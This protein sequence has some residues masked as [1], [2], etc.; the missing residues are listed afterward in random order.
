MKRSPTVIAFGCP[1]RSEERHQRY[2]AGT[3]ARLAEPDSLIIEKRGYDSIQQPLN[4]ILEESA[5]A[6]TLEAVVLLHEDTEIAGTTLLEMVRWHLRDPGIGVIG[7]VGAR[8]VETSCWWKYTMRGACRIPNVTPGLFFHS[9]GP[10][11]V[12]AVD[13]FLMIVSA[14][15]ARRVRFDERAKADF[16]AYDVDFC[17][18]AR[19][20]GFRVIVDDMDASHWS[21]GGDPYDT[22][23]ARAYA[24]FRRTWDPEHWPPE[25]RGSAPQG[26][27]R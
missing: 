3:I 16:H 5:Q 6:S 20:R 19:A 21:V 7:A 17:F 2:A 13:G 23:F 22:R 11:E 27:F 25:W 15:A 9:T 12:D 10:H 8:D 26:F 24:A 14:A 1:I 18:R 4:E